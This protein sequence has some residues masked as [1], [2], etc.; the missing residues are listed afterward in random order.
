MN[1][2]LLKLNLAVPIARLPKFSG[3]LSQT[4][5]IL[6]R[7]LTASYKIQVF[8]VKYASVITE[9]SNSERVW[10]DIFNALAER[11]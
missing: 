7:C 4:Y 2:V 1:A 5:L 10:K 3:V 6:R 11:S 9:Y 8:S